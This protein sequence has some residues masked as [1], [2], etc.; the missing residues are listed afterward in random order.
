MSGSVDLGSAHGSIVLSSEGATKGVKDTIGALRELETRSAQ[1]GKALGQL[2]QAAAIGR[3]RKEAGQ[4]NDLIGQVAGKF[5]LAA[6]AFKA[7]SF[8]KEA[9]LDTNLALEQSRNRLEALSGSQAK[10]AQGMALA[11]REF[12]AGRGSVIQFADAIATLTPSARQSGESLEELIRLAEILG[13]LK[14]GEGLVGATVALREAASGDFT[15]LA[16]RFEFSRGAIQRLKDE[17]VPNIEIVRRVMAQMGVSFSIVEKQ[18]QTTSAQAQLAGNRFKQMLA[19]MS[20]PAIEQMGKDLRELNK[21]LAN[22]QKTG[23]PEELRKIVEGVTAVAR[24][25]SI[26]TGILTPKTFLVIGGLVA[27]AEVMAEKALLRLAAGFFNTL[28]SQ[29][30]AVKQGAKDLAIFI[31]DLSGSQLLS[32]AARAI[33]VPKSDLGKGILENFQKDIAAFDEQNRQTWQ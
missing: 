23:V 33:P 14:P 15:S 11:R 30:D 18:A 31:A 29:V 7:A 19:D 12:D 26:L 10:A 1:S 25:W 32:Q 27:D 6:V 8:G 5:T 4:L 22:L 16:E 28:N 21:E 17:G 2:D 24:S 20:A 13:A 3:T 9:I